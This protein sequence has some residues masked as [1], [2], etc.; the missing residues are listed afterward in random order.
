MIGTT[1]GSLVACIVALLSG[2]PMSAAAA[3]PATPACRQV[4]VK[5]LGIACERTD[6]LFE[7]DADEGT[8]LLVHGNDALS[9]GDEPVTVDG[10]RAPVCVPSG[11]Y[12][13]V[14]IY[15]R[16]IDA[17][18]RYDE[19]LGSIRGL[20]ADSN[21]LLNVDAMARGATADYRVAC[22]GSGA[23]EVRHEVLPTPGAS[24]SFN[25]VVNDLRT[26]G[27][28]SLTD[29]LWVW[30]EGSVGA[31]IAGTGHLYWDESRS[32]NNRNNAGPGSSSTFA[33]LWGQTAGYSVRTWM[34]E[35]AHNLGAVQ[36]NAPDS[37]GAAHC[38]DGQDVM[39]YPDGGAPYNANVCTDRTHFDCGHDSYFDPDPA[40][41]DYLASNW[42]L[43][44]RMN[45]FIDLRPTVEPTST[46]GTVGEGDGDATLTLFR[47]GIID[48]DAPIAWTI[49]GGTADAA[50]TGTR[51]GDLTIPAGQRTAAF[52]IP[53]VGDDIDEVDETLVIAFSSSVTGAAIP[54]MT[55]TVLD[56]DADATVDPG[57]D[58]LGP[59]PDVAIGR[60]A[61]DDLRGEDIL[62]PDGV[63]QTLGRRV[64]AG[65][66]A[67]YFTRVGND[68]DVPVTFGYRIDAG[69][70]ATVTITDAQ[71]G[72]VLLRVST[73]GRV[74]LPIEPG[75]AR[76][77]RLDVRIRRGTPDGLR[78]AFKATL[79][80]HG[81]AYDDR[82]VAF[83]AANVRS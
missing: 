26:K 46:Q 58:P 4:P 48:L 79:F 82:D 47:A 83:G 1:G 22:T 2:L 27:Y 74:D 6:G 78:R 9:V 11:G 75:T 25:T 50:D 7:I 44:W 81:D 8:G 62:R 49:D 32:V 33:V 31:G 42:N 16:P 43:A 73:D 34:H 59:L 77:L 37:T 10:P 17:D 15:A 20:V 19:R 35:N 63:G 76:L 18:N 24:D 71:T 29:K 72:Q 28:T 38:T 5:G 57:D 23:V 21:A 13:M 12:R 68:G 51:S 14:V 64:R 55:V 65:T 40:V 3:T 30:Y 70:R 80:P 69:P 39:C 36:Q 45:R 61:D 66:I 56:D 54:R 60:R 52:T 53:I 67:S 41:G